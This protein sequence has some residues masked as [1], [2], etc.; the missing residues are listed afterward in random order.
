MV[1]R[2]WHKHWP[3]GIPH[4]IPL[5]ARTISHFLRENAERFP[6]REAIQF[7]GR[8]MTFG[9]LER[10][11]NQFANALKGMGVTPGTRVSLFLENCPQFIIAYHG[12]LK[13]RAVVVPANPMLRE[14][15]L[16]Y[17]LNDSGAR[18]LV[19]LDHL[20]PMVAMIREKVSLE[21]VIVTSYHDYLPEEPELPLHPS[22]VPPKERFPETADF[23]ECLRS[24][25]PDCPGGPASP[26][27]L[28]LL[29]YTSGTT[30]MPKGA[31]I[32]HRN[33]LSTVLIPGT[34]LRPA[35]DDVHLCVLPL[36]HVTGM[37]NSMN[38][39]IW[40]GNPI[41]LLA[42]FDAESVVR[43]I[44]RYR[45][46]KWVGITTMNMA[47]ANFPE[48]SRYDLSSLQVCTSGGASIP[49]EVLRRFQDATGS[50][51]LEGYGLSETISACVVNPPHRI[52]RGSI[53]LPLPNVE[54]RIVRLD[55]PAVDIA[56]GEVGEILVKG[57]MVMMGYWNRPE[58]TDETLVDGWLRTGD[59]ASMDEDG[60]LYIRGRKKELIKASGYS[61]FPSEVESLLYQH[62]AVAECAVIGIPH[63]YRGEDIKA[64]VVLKPECQSGCTAGDIVQWAREHIAAYKYP[65]QVE[66]RNALPK[67]G[68]GKI[69]KRLLVEEERKKQDTESPVIGD[70]GQ[71]S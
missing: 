48:I 7:Y 34:W 4:E 68:S 32:S 40:A 54:V 21:H 19:A 53:G 55:N 18:V 37:Q 15:E 44:E 49:L 56:P 2:R 26:G 63:P 64:F 69:L 13:A 10:E 50:A 14:M 58:E 70:S 31:M 65:R 33:L 12:A 67:S 17:E 60:Y 20:Y 47:V 23:R 57:P 16:Q 71:A 22:M 11:S 38:I 66:I 62:P 61:V 8:V 30:G 5:P 43:A 42:R 6:D 27:D 46:T 51:L 59:L 25:A 24:A 29:Q 35:H 45:I 39:P 36:F 52:V 3:E 28:A 9:E 1:L 41:V